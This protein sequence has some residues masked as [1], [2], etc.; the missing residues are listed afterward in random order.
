[1]S[2]Y[3]M[4]WWVRAPSDESMIPPGTKYQPGVPRHRTSNRN[5]TGPLPMRSVSQVAN[6]VGEIMVLPPLDERVGALWSATA[7]ASTPAKA[8][9]T[10]P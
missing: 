6:T 4:V 9:S 1:M 8:D 7:A 2:P 3:S 5:W 10:A